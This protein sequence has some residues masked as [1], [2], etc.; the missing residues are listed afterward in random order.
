MNVN[1]ALDVKPV[2]VV[3]VPDPDCVNPPGDD[4]IVHAVAGKPLNTTLPVGVKHDGCVIVP[5]SGAD[6]IV[7]IAFITAEVELIE[8]QPEEFVIVKV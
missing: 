6:G 3:V 2:K 8:V 1:I 4:V 7:G 5:T